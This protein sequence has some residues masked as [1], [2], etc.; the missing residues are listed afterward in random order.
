MYLNELARRYSESL[1]DKGYTY[2]NAALEEA[3]DQEFLDRNPIRKVELPKSRKSSKRH[4][5]AVEIEILWNNLTGRDR[6][7]L[8]LFVVCAFRPGELFALRWNDIESGKIRVD[9][10]VY[11]NH[12]G[13]PKTESSSASVSIPKSL[14]ME[15]SMWKACCPTTGPEDFVFESRY[16]GRP[17]DPRSY[18]RRFLKPLATKLGIPGL[19][20]QSLRRTFATQVQKLG[21]VK[22]AQAQLRHASASTTLNVY[23]QEMPES[24]RQTVEALDQKLFG[25][26]AG[27]PTVN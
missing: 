10:A 20:F 8:H 26:A 25:I 5:S 3:V 24:V 13:S 18:L 27:P 11:R 6:L 7:I 9:E 22:D 21:S 19:T 15:L 2:L 14:E 23:T 1:I 17:M 16:R 4:L 12:L